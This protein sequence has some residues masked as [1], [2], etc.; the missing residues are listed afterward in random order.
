[1]VVS[2]ITEIRPPG[3]IRHE[4]S[5]SCQIRHLSPKSRLGAFRKTARR[6]CRNRLLDGQ[7]HAG[8]SY[9]LLLRHGKQLYVRFSQL[10]RLR[11]LLIAARDLRHKRG[12]SRQTGA[13][14]CFLPDRARLFAF[15]HSFPGNRVVTEYLFSDNPLH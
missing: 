6:Q 15:H 14:L 13:P 12:A 8:V 3:G 4:K 5:H 10:Q 2:V 7:K 9:E 11:Q 1:M